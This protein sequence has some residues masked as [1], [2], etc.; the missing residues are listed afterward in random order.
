MENVI[1]SFPGKVVVITGAAAG[2]GRAMACQF[3]GAGANVAICDLKEE[4][5]R[6][7]VKLC[8]EKG[9]K[10]KFYTLDITNEDMVAAVKDE[11]LKDF[12][13]VDIL[14]NNAGV[15]TAPGKMGPPM[16]N[17]DLADWKRLIGVNLI[18]TVTV[19]KAFAPIFKEKKE[20]KIV[21]ISSQTAYNVT[22]SMPH[23][24]ASKLAI[25]SYTQSCSVELG[26][27]N[28]NVNAVCPGYIYTPIYHGA[29]DELISKFP[30]LLGDCKSEEEVVTKLA[31]V[32]TSLGRPETPD[33]IA[34]C[35]LFL[36]SDA[37]SEITGN[38]VIVDSGGIRR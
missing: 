2:L 5:A 18:G 31:R 25:V 23:Y 10:S 11:I 7:T 3:A 17:I 21:N 36:A 29:G 28:V 35:V 26:K 16:A 6:E 12:G 8:E 19:T 32:S 14:V 20:G 37:A 24:C 38:A 22:V 1:F 4:L 13:T 33:D 30:A 15:T 27:F 9:V 34:H